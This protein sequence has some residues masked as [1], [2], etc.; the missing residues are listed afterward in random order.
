MMGVTFFSR[1]AAHP[2]RPRLRTRHSSFL[3]ISE[4]ASDPRTLHPVQQPLVEV[5]S[6]EEDSHRG[7]LSAGQDQTLTPLQ[8]R[9]DASN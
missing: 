1:Y 9:S 8:Q 7:A 5:V 4:K 6:L 3:D 2:T